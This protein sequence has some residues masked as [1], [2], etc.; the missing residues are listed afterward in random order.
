VRGWCRAVFIPVQGGCSPRTLAADGRSTALSLRTKGGHSGSQLLA[1]LGCAQMPSPVVVSNMSVSIGSRERVVW[2][3]LLQMLKRVLNHARPDDAPK[4]DPGMPSSHANSECM[5][6]A[7][8]AAA[9]HHAAL[10]CSHTHVMRV[11][12]SQQ[13]APVSL[14]H[15]HSRGR[16]GSSVAQ[17]RDQCV[18]SCSAGLNF[19]SVYAALSLVYHTHSSPTAVVLAPAVIVLGLFKVSCTHQAAVRST[20]LWCWLQAGR[21]SQGKA[22]RLPCPA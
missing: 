8:Q 4:T 15:R 1:E 22:C 10:S 7:A 3:V 11:V 6:V 17:R 12:C 5:L 13:L 20:R 19:L 18:R 9:L 21:L 14:L 16:H 2:C